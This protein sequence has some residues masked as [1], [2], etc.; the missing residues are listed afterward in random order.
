MTRS[1][2]LGL[3]AVL[4]ALP[5]LAACEFDNLTGS[6]RPQVLAASNEVSKATAQPQLQGINEILLLPFQPS[7][8]EI[9]RGECEG[10]AYE[11][12]SLVQEGEYGDSLKRF[13]SQ[14]E[15]EKLR[16]RLQTTREVVGTGPSACVVDRQAQP[17]EFKLQHVIGERKPMKLLDAAQL[18]LR[19]MWAFSK[20][21]GA[22]KLQRLGYENAR[23]EFGRLDSARQQQVKLAVTRRLSANLSQVKR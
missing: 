17:D 16:V 8:T 15:E 12:F 3:L 20:E 13:A 1:K 4:L 9:Q 10:D 14:S 19:E 21:V 22:V 6:N 11:V 18:R 7:L 5:F 23:V 2:L